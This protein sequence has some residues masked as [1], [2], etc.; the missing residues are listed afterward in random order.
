MANKVGPGLS[1][2]CVDAPLESVSTAT[3]IEVVVAKQ[4]LYA[5]KLD[6]VYS[7]R[8]QNARLNKRLLSLADR[9]RC[10]GERTQARPSTL[11][12]V[13]GIDS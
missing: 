11:Q 1:D 9:S 13:N 10:T 6:G 5:K 8:A 3:G 4:W 7:G 2:C 12:K